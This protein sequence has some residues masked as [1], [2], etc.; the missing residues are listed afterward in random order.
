LQCLFWGIGNPV[1]K[2]GLDF[3][4]PFYCLS[5]RYI[6]AFLI[7]MMFLGKRV[8]S[9]MKASH[10]LP[11]VIAAFTRLPLSQAHLP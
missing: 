11:F 9:N 2:I 8:A 7:F 3:I 4:P 1:M 6:F 10:L 5:V